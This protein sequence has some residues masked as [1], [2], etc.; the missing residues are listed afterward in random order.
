[1]LAATVVPSFLI[2]GAWGVKDV[3]YLLF[4]FPAL[5]VLGADAVCEILRRAAAP[6]WAVTATVMALLAWPAWLTGRSVAMNLRDDNRW[7]ATRWIEATIPAGTRVIVDWSYVP[8]LIDVD[9]RD[10]FLHMRRGDLA[11]RH[12]GALR[13]YDLVR[14]E[15]RLEW[16]RNRDRGDYLVT[17]TS[18]YQRFLMGTVPPEG[19]PL[20]D[21]FLRQRALYTALVQAPDQLGLRR[22][23]D[24]GDGP[25]P[26]VLVFERVAAADS[27]G[28][29]GR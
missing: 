26:R 6:R 18:C 13:A 14:L 3:H 16:L 23:G 22:V 20:R 28:A 25:G 11:A 29:G 5:A 17:S 10:R 7:A 24:F 19:N 12:P 9:E 4:L 15:H 27:A 8:R 21:E 1:V 2:I